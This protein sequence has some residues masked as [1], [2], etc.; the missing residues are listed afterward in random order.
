M[1]QSY[2]SSEAPLWPSEAPPGHGPKQHVVKTWTVVLQLRREKAASL[3]PSSVKRWN[4]CSG[5]ELPAGGIA[6]RLTCA[7]G[8]AARSEG[9]GGHWGG[10]VPCQRPGKAS[11]LPGWIILWNSSKNSPSEADFE[12]SSK[13]VCN[14]QS[15]ISEKCKS[16]ILLKASKEVGSATSPGHLF[17]RLTSLIIAKCFLMFN[18]NFLCSCLTQCFLSYP[19]RRRQTTYSFPLSVWMHYI[20]VLLSLFCSP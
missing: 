19:Q 1:E 10:L 6:S 17:Q 14:F 5:A 4:V 3:A 11:I 9:W 12:R 20:V 15:R 2:A 13:S 16:C 8:T 18:L 7:A